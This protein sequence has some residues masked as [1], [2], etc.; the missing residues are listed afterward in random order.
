MPLR[1]ALNRPGVSGEQDLQNE[2]IKE[3]RDPKERG[4]PDI[5]VERPNA[6]TIH[7]FVIWSKWENLD[8]M[9]RSRIILDGYA[10]AVGEQEA[11][12]VTVA[13]GLTKPEADRLGIA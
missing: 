10:A 1:D 2:L 3:I 11:L 7:L 4:E 12:K 13:M 9:V 8:Q 6:S 5:I